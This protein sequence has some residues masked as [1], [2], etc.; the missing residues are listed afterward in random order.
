MWA[1]KQND[2]VN[3]SNY[4]TDH[5]EDDHDDGF[6]TDPLVLYSTIASGV[7]V[8]ILC[9]IAAVCI[10]NKRMKKIQKQM[11][12]VNDLETDK[13]EHQSTEDQNES[14]ATNTVNV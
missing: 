1:A 12:M 11:Q 13:M 14:Q 8:L 5:N 7:I 3:D 4:I 6:F 2:E 10:Y 9:I